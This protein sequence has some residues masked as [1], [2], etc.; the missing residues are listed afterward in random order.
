[1]LKHNHGRW[2]WINTGLPVAVM[3]G[4]GLVAVAAEPLAAQSY[5]PRE[6]G[7]FPVIGSRAAIWIAAQL[8][9]FFA[10]F[11]LGVPMFAVVAEGIHPAVVGLVLRDSDLGC[12]SS[13]RPD[14]TLSRAMG[15]SIGDLCAVHVGVRGDFLFRVFHALPVLLRLG[16]LEEGPG[17]MG[18]LGLGYSS[19]PMGYGGDADR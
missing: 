19:Q 14:H 8:H 1:M 15:L 17:K 13:F 12:N 3:L 5:T 4:I 18:P 11:V 16:S 6:Y 7:D 9:L 10:A 2:S